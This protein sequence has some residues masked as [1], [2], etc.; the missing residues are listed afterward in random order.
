MSGNLGASSWVAHQTTPA[1]G[2]SQD[3]EQDALCRGAT[4]PTSVFRALRLEAASTVP[5]SSSASSPIVSR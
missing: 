1:T 4:R 3:D 5:S 2:T